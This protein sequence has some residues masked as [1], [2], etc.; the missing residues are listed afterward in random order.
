M[1]KFDKDKV[2]RG[3]KCFSRFHGSDCDGAFPKNFLKFVQKQGWWGES[4]CHL[5][6]GLVD[7]A[8]GFKVDIRPE[9]YPD[10]VAD[11]T[12]TGLDENRFDAV[13]IDPPYSKELAQSLYKT[14]DKFYSINKF[15]KEACRI[16]KP[17]GLIITL[18]YEVPA[19]IKG[20][21]LIA[22]WGIYTIPMPSY[23]RCLSVWKKHGLDN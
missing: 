13:I 3:T 10:L 17:E 4:R 5:C 11:A 19:R 18:S 9:T 7:D 20:S 22:C 23:M 1:A 8:A 2:S 6:A 16:C 14:G 21:D 15:A 12:D